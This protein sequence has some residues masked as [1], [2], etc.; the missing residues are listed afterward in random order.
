MTDTQIESAP[1][2]PAVENKNKPSVCKNCTV[3]FAAEKP[4]ESATCPYTGLPK[5]KVDDAATVYS[6]YRRDYPGH[7][8]ISPPLVRRP[9][10]A[11]PIATDFRAQYVTTCQERFKPW[12]MKTIPRYENKAPKRKYAAPE[13]RY[14][15]QLL[16]YFPYLK[17]PFQFSP[18]LKM[19]MKQ[20]NYI[21]RFPCSVQ[22]ATK[23]ISLRFLPYR[24]FNECQE[25]KRNPSTAQ[26]RLRLW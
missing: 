14:I 8:R 16:F 12:D 9:Q 20:G 10:D 11:L 1:I 21:F 25:T 3:T 4:R 2:D 13:V 15:L 7:K 19:S 5:L 24:V 26:P 23:T 17:I 18:Q 22:P 6:T